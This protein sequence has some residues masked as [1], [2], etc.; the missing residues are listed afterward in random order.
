MD[1]SFV[2]LA[3]CPICHKEN[4]SLLMDTRLTTDHNGR[5][6]LRETFDMHTIDPRNPCDQ[7]REQYLTDGVL[8][9][10]PEDGSVAVIKD[11]A[12][13]RIFDRPIPPH[14]I[15]FCERQVLVQI[16]AIS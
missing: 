8:L 1:K 10:A 13:S 16:G 4:G 14:K 12:F 2:T 15:A 5:R 3:L 11:E 9:F 7:C 6:K